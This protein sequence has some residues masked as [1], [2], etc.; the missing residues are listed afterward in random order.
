MEFGHR[1]L[2]NR[3]ILADPRSRNVKN[4]INKAIKFREGFRPFPVCMR[5]KASM[6]FEIPKNE[7]LIMEK[8]AFVERVG[9]KNSRSYC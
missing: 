1:A 4:V 9:L 2:G 3:S 7:N 8:I 6:I 5:E